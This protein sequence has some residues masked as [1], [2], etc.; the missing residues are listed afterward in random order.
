MS[1]TLIIQILEAL[2]GTVAEVAPLFAQGE[3]VLSQDDAAAIH[4]ALAKAQ[5]ATAAPRP[6][7]DAALAA[8]SQ[9][10]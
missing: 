1:V 10:S 9:V 3:A 4:A 6:S 5:A 2:A 8:A 7:V